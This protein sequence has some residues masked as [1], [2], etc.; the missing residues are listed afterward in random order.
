MMVVNEATRARDRRDKAPATKARALPEAENAS[1]SPRDD[2][3]SVGL[4]SAGWEA[5]IMVDALK[6]FMST[7]TDTIMQQISK[8]VKKVE[9]AVSSTWPLPCFKCVPAAGCEPSYGHASVASH[10][11]SG[12][13]REAP[14]A[15][16][17]DR[18]RAENHDQSIG[19]EAS[20]SRRL[21]MDDQQ[22]QPRPQHRMQ[23]TYEEAPG[24]K[25]KS[26]PLGVK[27]RP[28]GNAEPWNVALTA[29]VRAVPLEIGAAS[30]LTSMTVPF[31]TPFST[32]IVKAPHYEKV[33]MPNVDLYDGTTDLEEH[34]GVYRAQ[35]YV[36]DVDDAAYCRFFP[37]TLKEVAQ[38]W[39]NGLAPES[40]SCFQDLNDRFV[41]QF[42]ASRKQRRT[43]IHLSKIKQGPQESLADF[44]KCFHQ[45]AVLIPDLEDRVADTSF[46]NG[47]KSGRFKFSLTKQKETTLQRH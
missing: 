8:Q 36:Q 4:P 29:S 6:N 12:G 30:S 43:S 39:F 41:S 10:H 34:L 3:R 31:S 38:A 25:S 21:S 44:I 15:D 9:E 33:K 19:A 11:H 28:L 22:G 27:G 42:I 24:S 13:R 16:R 35:M 26:I 18:S 45:E 46:L 5:Y 37:A 7:M 2:P 47:L 40:V 14:C 23:R 1:K 20:H 17:N 32:K